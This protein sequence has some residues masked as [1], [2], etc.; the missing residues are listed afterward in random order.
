MS[1]TGSLSPIA[2]LEYLRSY[3][4]YSEKCHIPI[5]DLNASLQTVDKSQLF[6][7][8]SSQDVCGITALHEAVIMKDTKLIKCLLNV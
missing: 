3:S 2:A 1:L 7:S 6:S 4:C 8:L 5:A